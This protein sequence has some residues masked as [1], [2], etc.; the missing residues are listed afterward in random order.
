MDKKQPASQVSQQQQPQ[1]Q[2][3]YDNT[4]SIEDQHTAA[5]PIAYYHNRSVLG[6]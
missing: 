3:I 4:I 5:L 6:T 1:V 2:I